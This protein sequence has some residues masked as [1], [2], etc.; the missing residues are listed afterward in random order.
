MMGNGPAIV[1]TSW[2]DG[3][4]GGVLGLVADGLTLLSKY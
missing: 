3:E 4:W 2:Y 1:L